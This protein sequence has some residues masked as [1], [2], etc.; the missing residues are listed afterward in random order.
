V[1][2]I[3]P[4]QETVFGFTNE[5]MPKPTKT[6]SFGLLGVY[7]AAK[8]RITSAWKR[9]YIKNIYVVCENPSGEPIFASM[10]DGTDFN[11]RFRIIR[12]IEKRP[13]KI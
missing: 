3:N 10:M 12:E 4:Y 6:I 1:I 9:K 7:R 8:I 13:P 11:K 2:C 5:P